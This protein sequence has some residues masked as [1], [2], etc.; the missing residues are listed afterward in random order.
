MITGDNIYT[1][2]NIGF[3]SGILDKKND[4]YIITYNDKDDNLISNN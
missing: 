1:A 2:V 3:S 4:I